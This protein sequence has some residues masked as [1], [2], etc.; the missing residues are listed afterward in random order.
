MI[1]SIVQILAIGFNLS[2]KKPKIEIFQDMIENQIFQG[3]FKPVGTKNCTYSI[4]VTCP[5]DEKVFFYSRKIP[6]DEETV[7]TF[8]T[9]S[10]EKIKISMLLNIPDDSS[11]YE[12]GDLNFTYTTQFDTF[13]KNVARGVSVEPAMNALQNFE[14]LLYN[15]EQ[16]TQVKQQQMEYLRNRHDSINFLVVGCSLCTLLIFTVLN[17]QQVYSLNTFI[18]KKK[19]I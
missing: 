19:L 10:Y 8:S 11:N 13:D 6:N 12:P 4:S 5:K 9:T 15:L 7:V 17:I 3:T 2:E 18:K 16:Q 1:F 14:K